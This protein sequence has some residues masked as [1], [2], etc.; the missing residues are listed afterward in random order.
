[1]KKFLIL[2]SVML[3]LAGCGKKAEEAAKET[4]VKKVTVPELNWTYSIEEA[5]KTAGEKNLTLLVNFTGSDWCGWCFRLRDEVF[6]HPEFI[7]YAKNSL[8][9]VELDYPQKKEQTDEMKAYNRKILEKYGVRGFP[10]ILLINKE[11]IEIGRT[12]YR[13]GGAAAY[14]EHIKS[15]IK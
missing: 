3:I 12:G 8:V 4:A 11:G 14:V 1:M 10:T 15:F 2:I 13:Q 6:I 5:L 7:E 9:L